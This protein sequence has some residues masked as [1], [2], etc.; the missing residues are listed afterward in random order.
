MPNRTLALL[1]LLAA[2]GFAV[3]PLLFPGF[4]GYDPDRFPIP[5]PDPPIQPA[6]F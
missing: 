1:V 3:S 5:Q 6:G 2:V 4:A